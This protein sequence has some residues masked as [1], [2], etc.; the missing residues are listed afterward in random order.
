MQISKTSYDDLRWWINSADSLFKPIVLSQ[1]EVTL[2]TDASSLGWGGVLDNVNI[3]GRW[4]P[5]E[6][7][8][9]INYLEMLAV[10]FAL[11]DLQIQLCGKHVCVRID[12]TAVS[13]IS[14]M[15]TRH[16]RKRNNLTRE[17][18]NWCITHGIFLTAAHI[19]G[20]ENVAADVESRKTRDQT[21]WALDSAIFKKGTLRLGVHPEIDIFASRLNYTLTEAFCCLTT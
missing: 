14:K 13:D 18:W 17:I 21:E 10:F 20:A 15:G 11:N 9:H 19:P 7:T 5:S 3:D 8:H 16:S 2:F 4:I 12:M 6:A 1:P